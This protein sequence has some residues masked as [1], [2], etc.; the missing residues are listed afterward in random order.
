MKKKDIN[1]E[2]FFSLLRAGLWADAGTADSRMHGFA[3]PVDWDKVYQ[4]AE[5]QSVLGVLLA[6]IEHSEVKPPQEV[7]LQIIGEVQIIEQENKA[8]NH[9]IAE[10]VERLR[11]NDIYA[12][13]LKGQGIAQCY[14][15]PLWRSSGDVDLF[16]NDSSYTVAKK[17]LLPIASSIEPEEIKGKH[18]GMTI[19]SWVVE[20]HGTL[21]CGISRRINKVLDEL[22]HDVFYGGSA[23]S[24][25]NGKTHVFLPGADIDA[26][27]VFTHFLNHFY[28]GGLGVRQVCDWC[29][30]LWTYRESLNHEVLESRIRKAGLM[31]EWKAFGAFAVEY[32]GM[33][34]RAIP[35]YSSDAKWKR[36][37]DKISA[38]ILD[39]GNMGHN[40]DMSYFGKYPY[41]I[42]KACSLGRRCSDL[43]CHARIFPLDSLRF[44]P[45]I[46][47]VGFRSALR[48]E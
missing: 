21:H 7:L 2:T 16:L 4:L 33:P 38:F 14:A 25:F 27:Y 18:L 9:F 11:N 13:L 48:R 36:K 23:R 30:L 41:F 19:D 12:L 43:I 35:L 1:S 26:I 32:L 6:G 29:R 20:L 22:Q 37:A 5:E 3:E 44:F 24:W 10:M 28:K 15:R 31:S 39:V 45:R 47:F 42:R 46:M 34:P 8:M 40:R 17:L